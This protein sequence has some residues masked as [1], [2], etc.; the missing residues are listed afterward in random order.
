M[1]DKK[2]LQYFLSCWTETGEKQLG[3]GCRKTLL[4]E[5]LYKIRR[6]ELVNNWKGR[7]I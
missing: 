6:K 3:K 2:K 5:E 1:C 4:E 7:I